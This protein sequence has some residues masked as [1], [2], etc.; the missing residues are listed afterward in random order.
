M[1]NIRYVIALWVLACCAQDA[2]AEI[3]V[4]GA[5]SCGAWIEARTQGGISAFAAQDWVIGYLSGVAMASNFDF[6]GKQ[7][8]NSLDN[9]SAFLWMDNYCRA[10]PLKNI[11]DG[12]D[13]LYFERRKSR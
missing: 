2:L 5:R 7:N 8:V 10:N 6:W 9:Q 3:T 11:A 4:R 1:T 12:A 13:E